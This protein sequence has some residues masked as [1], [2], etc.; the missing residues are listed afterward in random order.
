MKSKAF[1]AARVLL[2]MTI[3]R[4]DGNVIGTPPICNANHAVLLLGLLDCL[5]PTRMKALQ[6]MLKLTVEHTPLYIG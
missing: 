4:T 3:G 2:R 1:L 5:C 6:P